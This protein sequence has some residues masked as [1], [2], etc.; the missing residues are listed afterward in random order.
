MTAKDELA[1]ADAHPEAWEVE[2][3]KMYRRYDYGLLDR[4][5]EGLRDRDEAAYHIVHSVYV[6]GTLVEPSA[7]VEALVQRGL[8]FLEAHM[9]AAIHRA[10]AAGS[11]RSSVIRA[12]SAVK[13][14][15][16]LRRDKRRAAA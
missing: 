11:S 4:A 10:V 14:P 3:R 8:G 6:Y 2:R 13:H 16:L 9:V 7:M 5:L 1:D 15:A 12:P